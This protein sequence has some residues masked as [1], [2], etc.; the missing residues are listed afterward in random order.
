LYRNNDRLELPLFLAAAA[1]AGLSAQALEIALMN[2]TYA[3]KVQAD[4]M[5]GVRSGVNGTPA[6]FIQNVRHDGA[7]DYESL[8][9]AINAAVAATA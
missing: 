3:A 4:F 2:E 6:F 7:Y 9:A 1:T 8:T 5:G